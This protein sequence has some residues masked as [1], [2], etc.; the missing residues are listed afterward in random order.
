MIRRGVAITPCVKGYR[1]PLRQKND[2]EN[3][4][5]FAGGALGGSENHY[6]GSP[7]T[8]SGRRVK[9]HVH[10]LGYRAVFRIVAGWNDASIRLRAVT[11]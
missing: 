6:R 5:R 7:F 4:P 3:I 10:Q 2:R 11:R 1:L 8:V 9:A